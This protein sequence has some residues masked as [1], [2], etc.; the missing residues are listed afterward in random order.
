MNDVEHHA[1]PARRRARPGFL[2]FPHIGEIPQ[3]ACRTDKLEIAVDGTFTFQ[4]PEQLSDT[5]GLL[6]GENPNR[7]PESRVLNA[8]RGRE[9]KRLTVRKDAW[10]FGGYLA[11]RS[12]IGSSRQVTLNLS[13]N[14]TRFAEHVRRLFAPRM[15]AE[16]EQ[17]PLADLLRNR[18]EIADAIA[19][20]TLDGRDNILSVSPWATVVSRDWPAF[21][22]FYATQ[23]CRLV[24]EDFNRF[25]EWQNVQPGPVLRFHSPAESCPSIGYAEQHVEFSVDDARSL[26]H[27]FEQGIWEA[28]VDVSCTDR[29]S[30]DVVT[31]RTR[32][33]LWTETSLTD[34]VT[35]KVYA[36]AQTRLRA[37]V[38]YHA[39]SSGRRAPTIGSLVLNENWS[40]RHSF[41]EKIAGLQLDACARL[42]RPIGL[43]SENPVPSSA[44]PT[45]AMVEMLLA[46][47]H[48]KLKADGV[49]AFVSELFD[50]G[51]VG[52][53]VNSPTRNVA[54]AMKRRGL[55]EDV[56]IAM[57]HTHA[58][59]R[60]TPSLRQAIEAL[61][62][63]RSRRPQ[64]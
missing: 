60:P 17:V 27:H 56:H 50:Q 64:P 45:T 32:S 41:A 2:L 4:T 40:G 25:S 43:L 19:A 52:G 15:I 11:L 54:E 24:E 22:T 30:Y 9:R 26:Y 61:R 37:E 23:A 48:P 31:G 10:L 14:P 16:L 36:K 47:R 42:L 57:R 18:S 55:F 12:I 21:V 39:A 35:L 33:A 46:L 6:S 8:P 29:R 62:R 7:P 51:H 34:G 53:D 59:F 38:E 58:R 63:L 13:L 20:T 44:S 1:V 49:R 5:I 28:G 3:F